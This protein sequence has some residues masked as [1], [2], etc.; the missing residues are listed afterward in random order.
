MNMSLVIHLRSV[1]LF[2]DYSAC[3]LGLEPL[4]IYEPLY[5]LNYILY[6]FALF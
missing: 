3:I 2:K 1:V 4:I 5:L 6:Y